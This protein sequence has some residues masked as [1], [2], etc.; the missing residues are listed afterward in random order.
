MSIVYVFLLLFS[1]AMWQ[2]EARA[3]VTVLRDANRDVMSAMPRFD[4]ET[5]RFSINENQQPEVIGFVRAFHSAISSSESVRLT[6][7]LIAPAHIDELPFEI[8]EQSGE[9]STSR[10]LDTEQKKFYRFQVRACLTQTI[11]STS[12]VIVEVVDVNDNPPIFTNRKLEATVESDVPPGTR[13]VKLFAKDADAGNNSRLSFALMSENEPFSIDPNSGQLTTSQS[14][15]RPLYTIL[16]SVSDAGVPQ[17]SDTAEV[18]V[19]VKGTNPSPPAFDQKEYKAV[20]AAPIRAGQ[21]IGEVRATDPDPGMEGLVTYKLLRSD[22]NDH[23]KFMINSKTGVISAISPLSLEDGPIELGIEAT[24]NGKNL[25]RK[26]KTNMKIDIIDSKTLKFLPLPTTVYI[27]TEKAVGSVI[28]RVSAVSTDNENIKFRALQEN[29]QFVMDGDLLRVANHL[30]EGESILSIRAE[31]DTVHVD[32]QL[33]VIVMSDRD[34]YPV[35]PQLTY[36]FDVSTD[37]HFPRIV[38][39]FNAKLGAGTLRYTFFPPSPAPAGFYLDDKTGEL[40]VTSQYPETKRETVFVVVRAVN[41]QANKFYSDVGVAITP[42]ST[43]NPTL[44]FQQPNYNFEVYE[45]LGEGEAI[46]TISVTGSTSPAKLSLSPD[47]SFLGIHQNGT[48]FLAQKVDAEEIESLSQEFTVLAESSGKEN[49]ETAR[50]LIHVAIR[51]VNEFQPEFDEDD[52]EFSLERGVATPGATIG[53]VQAHDQD[54][55]EKNRLIYRVVGGSGRK[56]VFIQED[57]TIIVG[58]EQIPAAVD[59][60]DL[61]IEA[62]D[63]NGNHDS[64]HVIVYIDGAPTSSTEEH[65]PLFPAEPLVWNVT[66]GTTQSFQLQT[67]SDDVIYRIVGGND[68]GLFEL[69]SRGELKIV[70]ELDRTRQKSYTLQVEAKKSGV[71][72]VAEVTVNINPTISN[73]H[74]PKFTRDHYSGTVPLDAPIGF[75]IV[76][77]E[78]F[79]EDDDPVQYTF[80]GTGCAD[81]LGIDNSGRVAYKVAMKDRTTGSLECTVVVSDG[82]HSAE[83]MLTLLVQENE[84]VE[85]PQKPPNHAPTFSMAEYTFTIPQN[86]TDLGTVMATDPDGDLI[87]F[88]IE[89]TEY[90]NLFHVD[91]SGRIFVRGPLEQ[92]RYSFLVVAEDRGSPILSS[93]VN[94]KVLVEATQ[95]QLDPEASSPQHFQ[96]S[97]A[98]YSWRV[99]SG[100]PVGSIVGFVKPVGV[101]D[102]IS[103]SFISGDYLAIDS[104]GRVAVV[105]PLTETVNDVVIAMK[106][107]EILAETRIF[108]GVEPSEATT[109]IL[110]PVTTTQVPSTEAPA[111]STQSSEES[112]SSRTSELPTLPPA[113]PRI[114]SRPSQLTLAPT[115]DISMVSTEQ[116]PTLAPIDLPTRAVTGRVIPLDSG[117]FTFTSPI[118]SAFS[119]EGDF[120][121]GI[122]LE[123]KPTLAVQGSS[124]PPS[125]SIED[126]TLPFFLTPEGK[127]IMF[128]ADRER[129]ESYLFTIVAK[130]Q[131]QMARARLNVT[132]LDVNDNYPRFQAH[133]DAVGIS[134]TMHLGSPIYQLKAVDLDKFPDNQ[135]TYSLNSPWISIDSREGLLRVNGDLQAAPE[136]LDLTVE[137]QDSGKPPLKS[138]THLRILIFKQNIPKFL[139]TPLEVTQIPTKMAPGAHI[140][141][142]LAGPTV[143][144]Q[145]TIL[146]RLVDT[147]NGLFEIKHAG[148]LVLAR[149]PLDNEA[150]REYQLNVTAENSKGTDWVV[151]PIFVE[152]RLSSTNTPSTSCQFQQ[153]VYRA[154][155]MENSGAHDAVVRVQAG[156]QKKFRYAFHTQSKEF[157]IDSQSGQIYTTEPLDRETKSTYFLTVNVIEQNR[158]RQSDVQ[159]E[160]L[161]SK[162]SPWQT[163]VVVT[164]LDDNDNAPVFLHMLPDSTLAAVVDQNANLMSPVTHLQARDL[165]VLPGNLKFELEGPEADSFFLNSTN[166]LVQL[167]KSL[168]KSDVEH[169]ELQATVTDGKHA[170]HVPLNIYVLSVDTNVVQLTKNTPHSDIDPSAVERKLTE[171]LGMD[172]RI[173]VAQP[174]VSDDGKTDM[175]KSH[176]FVYSL[177]N[178]SQKPISR[179][180]LKRLLMAHSDGL[181]PLQISSVSLLSTG[182]AAG[183]GQFLLT[184]VLLVVLIALLLFICAL[185]MCCAKRRARNTA[186][187]MEGAYMI[188]SVGSGPRPYD[189]ENI[190][191]L[192]AQNVLAGRPLPDPQEHR[193]D[194]SSND[195]DIALERDDT[196]REFSNSVRERPTLLQSALQRQNIHPSIANDEEL[197]KF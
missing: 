168:E 138:E 132:I 120:K 128:E 42:V 157:E 165:D 172:T 5:Y 32:H 162:L 125:F 122:E 97:Q 175:K 25:K 140:K 153:K 71:A 129:H 12:D 177:D 80:K 187:V 131:G 155:V 169:F 36:D 103:Y 164:V 2:N 90:R 118:Y 4:R 188:N 166:G 23:Q 176:V 20:I 117:R 11:C 35:F 49:P 158:K 68:D 55:S 116:G 142:L 111:T 91:S 16:V 34:K 17:R 95:E 105:K 46:G 192:T 134:R 133:P 89:P 51:D 123:I 85:T 160:Q 185:I 50:A 1:T 119:L 174:F 39:Q 58:D 196:T 178:L 152:G 83:T 14:L 186:G 163:L 135:V 100:L 197:K 171:I 151:L 77:M 144:E 7:S 65:E 195:T 180:E 54:V 181:H 147:V 121:S 88:S 79:D 189:V 143:S 159:V 149:R 62:V 74:A 47:T 53:R 24:D 8:H 179:D 56:L 113:T 112:P 76:T 45:S 183:N 150:G 194:M 13:I 63:R 146:Y 43:T 22:N 156:C 170:V 145:D 61:I 139:E 78:A 48:L 9:V 148:E 136:S 182:N 29:S 52:V 59:E 93:F 82:E 84:E 126:T 101:T 137:A 38:H 70:S 64:T 60:F 127:L 33:K 94:V 193:I 191:R 99:E 141:T 30:V 96:F 108:V 27:S 87:D 104:D 130:A 75:P 109:R 19:V 161:S 28:L 31:T 107:G 6:Y 37:G 173:L 167:A 81:Q 44:R 115:E 26:V 66:E 67:A 72:K 102:G 154:Q 98:V 110:G 41:M 190:S 18:T 57:G 124:E 106:N 21:V 10:P 69:S 3:Q 114:T 184:V 92:Q 73:A 15:T 86:S 40:F